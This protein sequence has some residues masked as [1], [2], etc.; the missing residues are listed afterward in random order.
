MTGRIC[1]VCFTPENRHRLSA[2]ESVKCHKQ[3]SLGVPA[4]RIDE[5]FLSGLDRRPWGKAGTPLDGT[6]PSSAPLATRGV[7][8]MDVEKSIPISPVQCSAPLA[9]RGVRAMD[10]E[11]SIPISPV[12]FA[13]PETLRIRP[14]LLKPQ[15]MNGLSERMLVSHYE[16]N[17]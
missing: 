7:R 11:K 1:N 8:A 5:R 17:Y 2:S 9:T 4:R 3:T 14:F 6:R 12:Q 15:W 13:P 10:V 16:N